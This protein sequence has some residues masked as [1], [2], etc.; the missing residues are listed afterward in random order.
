MNSCI[1]GCLLE[2]LE[3]E[4]GDPRG[5][6]GRGALS[7]PMLGSAGFEAAQTEGPPPRALDSESGDPAGS[8]SGLHSGGVRSGAPAPSSLLRTPSHTGTSAQETTEAASI[9]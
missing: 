7:S 9:F 6:S 5:R 3:A 1:Q 4:V 2:T 8:C